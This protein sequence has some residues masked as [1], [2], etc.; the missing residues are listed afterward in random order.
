VDI[1][2]DTS[3]GTVG[4]HRRILFEEFHM[5]GLCRWEA[6]QDSVTDASGHVY[7]QA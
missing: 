7:Q 2:T 4:T 5:H 6:M 1:Q 3:S